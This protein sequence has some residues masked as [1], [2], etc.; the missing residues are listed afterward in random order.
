MAISSARDIGGILR[1][2]AK[3]QIYG[4]KWLIE[5]ATA[6]LLAVLAI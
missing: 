5:A 6:S 1:C 2:H 4:K 3:V